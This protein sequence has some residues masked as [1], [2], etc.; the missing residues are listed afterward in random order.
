MQELISICSNDC[1]RIL[2]FLLC[3]RVADEVPKVLPRM[4]HE[5][6]LTYE[7]RNSPEYYRVS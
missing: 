2:V 7:H 5:S 1:Q 4:L 6:D 3:L